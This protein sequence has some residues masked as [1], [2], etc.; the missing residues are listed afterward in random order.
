M[1][2]NHYKSALD[3]MENTLYQW[4]KEYEE[5]TFNN[6]QEVIWAF[7]QVLREVKDKHK[8]TPSSNDI[9]NRVV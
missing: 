2:I 3:D 4:D 8:L 6:P 1:I 5:G 7:S 9:S